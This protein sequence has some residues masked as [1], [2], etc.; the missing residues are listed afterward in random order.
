MTAVSKM[1][2]VFS[3][4]EENEYETLIKVSLLFATQSNG[5]KSQIL[6]KV[7]Y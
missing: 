4:K 6:N 2:I 5:F 7:S 1:S 3:V